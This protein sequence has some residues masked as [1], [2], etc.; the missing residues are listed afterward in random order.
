MTTSLLT[1]SQAQQI[2]NALKAGKW[3]RYEGYQSFVE[4]IYYKDGAFYIDGYMMNNYDP[5]SE[6][7]P[8]L[9]TEE[10]FI[11]QMI[12]KESRYYSDLLI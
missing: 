12:G 5:T 10:A 7:C 4:E 9:L 6:Y 1:R 11:E 8:P 2:A 3:H